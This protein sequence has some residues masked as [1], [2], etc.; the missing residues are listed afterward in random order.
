MCS[1]KNYICWST[2]QTAAPLARNKRPFIIL[3]GPQLS[4]GPRD[5]DVMLQ[6][7]HL[8][9]QS[10]SPPLRYVL[11]A[12]VSKTRALFEKHRSAN[13]LKISDGAVVKGVALTQL[14]RHKRF[15]LF[16]L[17]ILTEEKRGGG[18]GVWWDVLG[19][20]PLRQSARLRVADTFFG[21][22]REGIHF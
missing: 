21:W 10:N 6:S 14:K 4:S 12:I 17:W 19:G 20:H 9:R 22:P 1:K 13:W 18:A 8:F 2:P 3:Y 7:P 11:P 15:S 16:N 5:G